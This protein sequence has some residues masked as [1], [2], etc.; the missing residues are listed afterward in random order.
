[1][2]LSDRS[3]ETVLAVSKVDLEGLLGLLGAGLQLGVGFFRLLDALFGESAKLVG[4]LGGI[5]GREFN[6]LDRLGG[7]CG[8]GHFP[9]FSVVAALTE[10]RLVHL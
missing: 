2:V 9:S 10:S 1:M 5:E 3:L 8:L 4:G 6:V 7:S